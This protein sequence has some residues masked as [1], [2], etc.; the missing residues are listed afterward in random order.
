M[1]D[2]NEFKLKDYERI[3]DDIIDEFF[4]MHNMNYDY[5]DLVKS[6]MLGE[7]AG[8]SLGLEIQQVEGGL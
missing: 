1:P 6:G 4:D 2:D 7:D 8:G 5:K 3:I